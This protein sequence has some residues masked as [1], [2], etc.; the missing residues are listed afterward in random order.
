MKEYEKISI[1]ILLGSLLFANLNMHLSIG[2]TILIISVGVSLKN[3]NYISLI[4]FALPLV[5]GSVITWDKEI[6]KGESYNCSLI[7]DKTI[8]IKQINGKVLKN[9]MYLD[10]IYL[11]NR[12]GMFDAK[13]KIDKISKNY[14]NTYVSG[15][16]LELK[17]SYFNKYRDKI[18]GII[19]NTG[20]SYDVEAFVKAIVL[21]ERNGLGDELEEEYRLVGATHILSISG[22]HI[23][24]VI[25]AFLALFHYF[26]FS[27]RM[28]YS[29]TLVLLTLYVLM[30]GNNPAIIRSY[31]MGFLFLLSKLF[32]EKA[33]IKKSFCISIIICLGLNPNIIKD[34]S[35][36][37]S[38]SAIF[39]I[40]YVYEAFKRENIYLN[41]VI[42]SFIIQ[43]ILT[44]ITLF[45][46]GTIPI[47]TFLF[48]IVIVIWGDLLINLIFIGVFLES[49]KLGIIIREIV[50]FFYRVLDV[51][52][53]T[54][55]KLPYSSINSDREI[56]VYFFTGM[57]F[58]L[59]LF[60][61]YKKSSVYLLF[62][63][64]FIY[65]FIPYKNIVKKDFVYF[66]KE[67]VLLSLNEQKLL[68][69]KDYIEKSRYIITKKV[70]KYPDKDLLNIKKGETLNI[71]KVSITYKNGLEWTYNK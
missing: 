57:L 65:T 48:N 55:A 6:Y 23:S 45:Y 61:K 11:A 41:A 27:Y 24:I 17:E 8:E 13:I 58:V 30:L 66:G 22:L 20:Y 51:F 21:G 15:E 64:I 37:M 62:G 3:K 46:F 1:G 69:Y 52:I 49:I 54:M 47:Y 31:I 7:V 33:S 59:L 12:V 10:N 2:L 34:L 26:G 32:F 56:P 50:E 14:S 5:V 36:L 67:K 39:G 60:M 38:Y 35:F 18:R 28:K 9:K 53:K 71:G 68:K 63:L 19:E 4:F 70:L 25:L 16:I 44:P 29:L 42:L 43:I 40:V